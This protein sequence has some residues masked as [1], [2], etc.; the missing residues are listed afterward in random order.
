MNELAS[1]LGCCRQEDRRLDDAVLAT[2]VHV[3]GS[4]YRRPGARMLMFADGTR[5]GTISGGC[6]E[7][8]VARKAWW[9]TDEGAAVRVFDNSVEDAARDFGL[10]CN[11]VITVLLERV[12][13]RAVR[14]LLSFL[15]PRQRRGEAGVVATVIR[16]DPAT[17]LAP[18]ARGY[19]DADGNPVEEIGVSA[20]D[21][22]VVEAVTA[23][24]RERRSRLLRIDQAEIF[25]EW[26][27]PP[28]RLVLF[29]AGLDVVPVATM[30]DMLGWNVT[31]ADAKRAWT[32]P[33]RFPMAAR[34]CVLPPDGD[35]AEID[36]SPADAVVVMTHNYPLDAL[37]LPQLL[38]AGPRYLG[39]LGPRSRAERL[40]EEIGGRLEVGFVHAPVGLDVGGEQPE[41]I[42]LSIVAEIQ[43]V[44]HAQSGQSLRRRK[45]AIHEP[46]LET[47]AQRDVPAS[48]SPEWIAP[49]CM[50]AYG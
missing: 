50:A 5:L 24:A 28:Q 20:V 21:G 48:P 29:G 18:G 4:A 39:L 1:I 14:E 19:Y 16:C 43:C 2:V 30:A 15:E 32:D 8:E 6:L 34:T 26:I 31:V 13:T 37:L 17:G 27:A 10:G 25:V 46:A 11:G 36:V 9:W 12:S 49:A 45:G 44:L 38:A 42:A 22:S 7:T 40:F 23:T 35:I 41:A 47:G 33:S 3:R